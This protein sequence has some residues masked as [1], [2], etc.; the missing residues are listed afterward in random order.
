ME[1]EI[2]KD[3]PGYEGWYKASNTGLIKSLDRF[4]N[5]KSGCKAK[6]GGKILRQ[7]IDKHG[8]FKVFISANGKRKNLLTHRLIASSFIPNTHNKPQVNHKDGNKLNN[9]DWNLEWNTGFENQQHAFN[10]GLNATR[11][12]EL[13]NFSKLK[14]K[15]IIEIRSMK[16]KGIT[17]V[18]IAHIFN[19]SPPCISR[20]LNNIRWKHIE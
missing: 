10:T 20:I 17:G 11:K 14:S 1:T 3:I 12:G 6:R 2:W 5:S 7:R 13:S 9:N 19:V 15:D 8:Y 18:E 4:V 16:R